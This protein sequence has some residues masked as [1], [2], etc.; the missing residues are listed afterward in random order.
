MTP[1]GGAVDEETI[2]QEEITAAE[3]VQTEEAQGTGGVIKVTPN[4]G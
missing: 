2:A 4:T 1:T 3:T